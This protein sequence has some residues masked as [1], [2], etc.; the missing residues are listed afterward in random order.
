MARAA[1]T[2]QDD[3]RHAVLENIRF[4]EGWPVAVTSA[5]IHRAW[6]PPEQL[7]AAVEVDAMDAVP[8]LCQSLPEMA[9]ELAGGSLKEQEHTRRVTILFRCCHVFP[10]SFLYSEQ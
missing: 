10:S 3:V 8:L 9:E 4:Q 5:V 7:V 6:Q 1:I 2:E